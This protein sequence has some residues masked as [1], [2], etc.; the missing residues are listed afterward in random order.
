MWA[1]QGVPVW[2]TQRDAV[3]RTA[4]QAIHLFWNGVIEGVLSAGVDSGELR[5]DLDVRS[6]ARVVSSFV[7]VR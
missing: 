3:T 7:M 6:A 5:A 1:P 2:I 4:F